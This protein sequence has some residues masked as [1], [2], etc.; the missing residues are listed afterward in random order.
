MRKNIVFIGEDNKINNE[1]YQLLSQVVET[2]CRKEKG[3]K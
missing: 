1:L 3:D 2:Y